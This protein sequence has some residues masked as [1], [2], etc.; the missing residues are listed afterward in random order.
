MTVRRQHEKSAR[1]VDAKTANISHGGVFLLLDPPLP[2]GTTV[3]VSLV[4]ATTW[5]PLRLLGTVRWVRDVS[6][7]VRAG[8]GVMF[9][10]LSPDQVIA[11]TRLFS[12]HG[13][14]SD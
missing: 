14:E 7:G 9:D 3:R 1:E 12:T 4:S 2:V 8:M 13:Y 10:G 5:E 11:L 6:K